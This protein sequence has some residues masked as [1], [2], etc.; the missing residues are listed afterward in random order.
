MGASGAG[1]FLQLLSFLPY[2][3]TGLLPFAV[4]TLLAPA[5]GFPLRSGVFGAGLVAVAALILV[6]AGSRG[7]FGPDAGRCPKL[8]LGAPRGEERFTYVAL[9]LAAL[10]G[11]ILQ[12]CWHTGEL[13]IPLGALGILAGY[14]YFAPPLN[15]HR[16]GLGGAA[17]ALAFGLLPVL[18]GF[19]LQCGHLVTEVLLYGLPLTL[20]GYNLFLIH[21]FPGP[22]SEANPDPPGLVARQGPIHGALLYTVVNILTMVGLGF[23]LFFPAFPLPFRAGLWPLLL[24]AVVNQELIKRRAYQDESRLR[25][26]CGLTLGLHLGMGLI[27]T[28]MLAQRI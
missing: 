4:G 5:S 14:F 15:W 18:T 24:L 22:G 20:A 9:A 17:G 23:C 2:V 26:L 3:I 8:G 25:L 12:F 6:A 11:I 13:T 7:T 10:L 19:Y 28:V 1:G 27:F 21:G 16:R